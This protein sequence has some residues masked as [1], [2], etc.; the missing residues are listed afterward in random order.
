MAQVEAGFSPVN[1][2][3]NGQATYGRDEFDSRG[4]SERKAA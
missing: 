4:R 2:Q 3:L 1:N